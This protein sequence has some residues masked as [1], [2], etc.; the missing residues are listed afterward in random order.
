[1]ETV[2]CPPMSRC[3]ALLPLVL[4]GCPERV[5]VSPVAPPAPVAVEAPD[6]GVAVTAAKVEAWLGYHRELKALATEDGGEP[7]AKTKAKA[8]RALRERLGLTEPEL[9]HLEALISAVVA[10]RTIGRLTGAEAV[11]EFDKATIALKPEQRQKVEQAFGDV[12]TRA[13]QAAS[14][15]AE[16]ARFGDEAVSLVLAREAEVTATW[17]SLLDGRGGRR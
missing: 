1:M 2:W 3:L 7:D 15:E 9:E 14:L 11:R 10:Q 4:L 12:R 5:A 16:R 6:A 13:Q 8:E 17:D